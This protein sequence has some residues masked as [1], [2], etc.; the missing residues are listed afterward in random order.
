MTFAVAGVSGRTGR[1]V[2]NTLID[3]GAP[4]RAI[5]RAE[6][7]AGSFAERGAE[8]AIADLDDVEALARA[9]A[10][11]EGAFVLL[12]PTLHAPD[13]RAYQRGIVEAIARASEAARLPHL[14][15]LSS[16]G[17]QHSAE[18]GPIAGLYDAERTL[19]ALSTTKSTFIRAA[20]FMENFRCQLG[21]LDQGFLPSFVRSD[22][23]YDMV[24][25]ADVGNVAARALLEG[26]SWTT[27]I[28]L[29]GPA[30]STDDAAA[31]LS[32][33][34]GRRIRVEQ[35]PLDI[36]APVLRS[37]GFPRD[38]AALY[39][40]MLTGIS[41]GHV[42]WEGGHRRMRGTIPLE[43]VLAQ[44]LGRERPADRADDMIGVIT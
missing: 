20:S 13:F 21:A 37:L 16:I 36:A 30:Y 9:L 6:T 41:T 7:S 38:L 35:A 42:A 44:L 4:V 8:V 19:R 29:G 28:E 11:T 40:E 12:P 31:I 32:R 33:L 22:L 25:T 39:R 1:V 5:V 3:H 24:A 23:K 34:T 15:L 26:A 27:T 18:N 43:T 17:A 2:A 14:V 10:G